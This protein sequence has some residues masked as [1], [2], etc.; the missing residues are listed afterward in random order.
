MTK[1]EKLLNQYYSRKYAITLDEYNQMFEEQGGVCKI[2]KRP[3][4]T[5]RLSVDHDHR[6]ANK[7]KVLTKKE[8]NRWYAY[9]PDINYTA[10]DEKKNKT[11]KAVKREIL[12]R[13]VRGLLCWRCNTALQKLGDTPSFFE[14]AAEYLYDYTRHFYS[15]RENPNNKKC[16]YCGHL[17]SSHDPICKQLDAAGDTCDCENYVAR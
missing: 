7:S 4:K 13:S 12:R 5:R 10:I 14:N 6:L 17:E 3:P 11:I 8:N 15:I 1:K 2:C 9:S 16:R